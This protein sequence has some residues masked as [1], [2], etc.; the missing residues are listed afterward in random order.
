M[1]QYIPLPLKYRP[2]T[3]DDVV[4]QIHVVRVLKRSIEKERF[5]HCYIF[6]GPRGSGKTSLA[7]IFAKAL[8]CVNGPTPTPCGTCVQCRE[9]AQSK[10]PDVLEIDGA[11]NRGINEIRNIQEILR[12]RP[13][14]GH[15][16]IVIIDEVHMLTTEAFNALLKTLEEPPPH[17]VFIMATTEPHKVPLTILSRSQQLEFHRIPEDIIFSRLSEVAEKENID[18]HASALRMIA[19]AGDGSL[20]DALSLLEQAVVLS[21]GPITDDQVSSIL[22][23]LHPQHVLTLMEALVEGDTKHV[24]LRFQNLLQQGYEVKNIL[25]ELLR[26][27]RLA[28]WARFHLETQAFN[29]DDEFTRKALETIHTQWREEDII[30]AMHII[31]ECQDEMRFSE[32]P[33][34]RAELMLL[35]L[36][37]MSK[38]FSAEE[39]LD[40]M[41]QNHEFPEVP[42]PPEHRTAQTPSEPGYPAFPEKKPELSPTPEQKKDKPHKHTITKDSH[43]RTDNVQELTSQNLEEFLN[44]WASQK[45]F[46]KKPIESIDPTQCQID[47]DHRIITIPIEKQ[48]AFIFEQMWGPAQKRLVENGTIQFFGKKY[49]I[50]VQYVTNHELESELNSHPAPPSTMHQK[51]KQFDDKLVQKFLETLGGEIIHVDVHKDN[52]DNTSS[53]DLNTPSSSISPDS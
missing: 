25:S 43:T 20:R 28:L 35:R 10:S 48:Y 41:I 32:M 15:Y 26:Y 53:K 38:L 22:G 47:H 36:T 52:K 30:R 17:V 44:W 12:Y 4:H 39:V 19:R 50:R 34:I 6:A 23:L 27:L 14:S 29:P 1:K 46:P 21:E 13:L 7:R 33:Q 3:F 5:A 24:M 51:Q 31:V 11:S 45:G 42:N 37:Y 18:I 49:T 9:I 2:Q 40:F 16:K 8:N